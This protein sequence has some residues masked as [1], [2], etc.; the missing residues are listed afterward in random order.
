MHLNRE[1]LNA[2][3][4]VFL[5]GMPACDFITTASADALKNVTLRSEWC[6]AVDSTAQLDDRMVL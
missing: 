5:V 4:Q 6:H 2:N 1:K 3:A